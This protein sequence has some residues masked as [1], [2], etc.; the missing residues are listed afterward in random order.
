MPETTFDHLDIV[1]SLSRCVDRENIVL[2]CEQFC[3]FMGYESF[4]LGVYLPVAGE[5][6]M[7]SN[8]PMS[9]LEKYAKKGYIHDDPIVKHCVAHSEV[10]PWSR[11][12][13]SRGIEGVAER[14]QIREAQA[15][16]LVNGISVPIHGPGAES[17][18][19]S[20]A[21]QKSK[22]PYTRCDSQ[23][24]LDIQVF[25]QALHQTLRRVVTSEQPTSRSKADLTE[26]EKECLSWI[27]NGKTSWEIS[28]I[29]NISENTVSYHIKNSINKMEVANRAEAVAKAV[30]DSLIT[31]F[32]R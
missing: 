11:I 26:R 17:G 19:L 14:K 6:V 10:L 12:N 8:Y 4:L 7:L 30:N 25:S 24:Q 28:Q 29:L 20:L 21:T 31:L 18:L 27:A 22:D 23:R 5:I 9:W 1:D 15:N 16:G 2:L 3:G 32:W 13:W